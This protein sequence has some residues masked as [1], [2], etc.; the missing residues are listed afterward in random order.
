MPFQVIGHRGAAGH[1]PENTLAGFRLALELGVDA[2]E[3]DLH[4]CR[5]GV[6]VVIHDATVD[7]TTDGAGPVAEL[8]S[9]ELKRL[10]AGAWFDR[11]YAGERIPFFDEALGV[12]AGRVPIVLEIKER[13][14]VDLLLERLGAALGRHRR[15]DVVISSFSA[16]SLRLARERLPEIPRAWL[17]R[18]EIAADVDGVLAAVA[19]FEPAELCPPALNVSEAWVARAHAAGY[20]VRT[21]GIPSG[22]TGAM[23]R[24]MRHVLRA[25]ADGTTADFPDVM[26]STL[27]AYEASLRPS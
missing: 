21:W 1:A 23:V 20:R 10:D 7:R 4:L 11:E 8:T 9:A 6:P 13:H 3:L 22:E 15:V 12:L 5:D 18:G 2:V 19:A 25:G 14:R 27:R 16:D 26:R 24:A 17:I